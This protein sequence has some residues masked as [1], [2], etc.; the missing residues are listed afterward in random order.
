MAVNNKLNSKLGNI[1]IETEKSLLLHFRRLAG[2]IAIGRA[3][4]FQQMRNWE[5][6]NVRLPPLP[7]LAVRA[8]SSLS[9]LRSGP[10]LAVLI[11]S[12]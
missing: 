4:F 8:S 6:V 2:K 1:V 11:H 5:T 9:N 7:L 12:L 10:I 3:S